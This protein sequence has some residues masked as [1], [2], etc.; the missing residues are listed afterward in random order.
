M[1]LL[2]IPHDHTLSKKQCKLS[3]FSL[4]LMLLLHLCFYLLFQFLE[5][6]F[7]H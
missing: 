3:A 2:M 4:L 6:G 5:F 1:I 7:Q